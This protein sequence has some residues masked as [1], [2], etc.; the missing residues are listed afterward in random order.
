MCDQIIFN[1][2]DETV[3]MTE[4]KLQSSAYNCSGSRSHNFKK[5]TTYSNKH[6]STEKIDKVQYIP[7][8]PSL[9]DVGDG[10]CVGSTI[11]I[12]ILLMAVFIIYLSK[13]HENINS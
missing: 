5:S 9:V 12:I 10:I 4:C 8:R 1:P 6:R 2:S 11:I 3:T 7:N 13:D